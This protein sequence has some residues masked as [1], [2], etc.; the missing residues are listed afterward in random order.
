MIQYIRRS[1]AFDYD[2]FVA[3]SDEQQPTLLNLRRNIPGAFA[4]A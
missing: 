2:E 1:K 4:E 3:H